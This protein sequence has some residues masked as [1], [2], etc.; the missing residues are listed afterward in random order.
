MLWGAGALWPKPTDFILLDEAQDTNP[1][2][3]EIFLAQQ[4][5]RICVGDPAQQIYGWRNARDVMTGFPAEHLHLT[6]S[7]RFGPAI[8]QVANRWL[9]H[10]ESEMRLSG[11]G[12]GTSRVGTVAQPDAVLCRGNADAMQEVLAY[13][14]LG[15]P[16]ALTGG[17]RALHRIATAAIE[18]KAGRRTSHPELFLFNSWGEVQDYAEHDK[19][20]QDLKAIVNWSTPTAPTRSSPRWTGSPRSRTRRSPCPPRTRPRAGS[21]PPCGS[22]RASRPRPSSTTVPSSPSSRAR[23]G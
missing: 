6:Q 21:G 17:G 18:L 20:A 15:I 8:T 5:Q 16:V 23:P 19:A 2:L 3:E 10:A 1:V 22:A 14:E 4:A 13:M 9:Q 7:F 11:H 12:R